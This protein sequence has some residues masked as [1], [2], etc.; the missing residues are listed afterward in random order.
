MFGLLFG[1]A[2]DVLALARG[3]RVG[4]VDFVLGRRRDGKLDEEKTLDMPS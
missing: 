1:V 4:Y 2:Q 3:R